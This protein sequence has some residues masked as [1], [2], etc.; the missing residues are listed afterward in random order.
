MTGY[1]LVLYRPD[2][3]SERYKIP[4]AGLVLGRSVENDIVLGYQSVSRR[5]ARIWMD[6]YDLYIEDLGSA[7]GLEVNGMRTMRGC[8]D[9]GDEV[10][11]GEVSFH[12]ARTSDSTLGQSFI[13]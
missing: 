8:L 2:D 9:D 11:I 10:H 1:E 7:N 6:G 13:T 3:T 5:H 4:E 12:V